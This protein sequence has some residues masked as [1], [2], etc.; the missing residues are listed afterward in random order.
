MTTQTKSQTK[1]ELMTKI[2]SQASNDVVIAH[3][4]K[5]GGAKEQSNNVIESAIIIKGGAN[6]AFSASNKTKRGTKWAITEVSAAEL[7]TL[8][9]HPGFMRRVKAGFITIGEEPEELKSD[10]SAQ[11]TEAQLETKSKAKASTGPVDE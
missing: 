6:V 11:M 8:E 9:D 3:Y 7:K 1:S 5:K 10:K 4:E 2:Y